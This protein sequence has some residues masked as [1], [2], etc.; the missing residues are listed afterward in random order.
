MDCSCCIHV[1]SSSNSAIHA[2]ATWVRDM[3]VSRK[4]NGLKRASEPS[5]R[6]PSVAEPAARPFIQYSLP[7]RCWPLLRMRSSDE[8][9]VGPSSGGDRR[10]SLVLARVLPLL[11]M[12]M[13]LITLRLLQCRLA[14]LAM[15]G[16]LL[17]A[18]PAAAV[19]AAANRA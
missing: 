7:A 12:S 2:L 18:V 17:Q 15:T 16:D 11:V 1:E 19:H 13:G 4:I 14:F 3:G 9:F 6:R 8:E 5:E 10:R